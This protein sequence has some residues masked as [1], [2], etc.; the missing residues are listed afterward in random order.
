MTRAAAAL[1]AAALPLVTACGGVAKA[2]AATSGVPRAGTVVGTLRLSARKESAL[3][4]ARP[5]QLYAVVTTG[6]KAQ[7]TV[8]REA[9][10][11][12]T[13]KHVAFDLSNYLA[14]VS[15]GPDGVYA[16]TAVIRRFSD[17]PDQLLRIDLQTLRVAAR[18][19]FGAS[20]STVAQGGSLWAAIGDGRIVR[21]DPRTLKI[22]RSQQ[23]LTTTGGTLLAPAV[24]AGSL[25]VLAGEAPKLELVRLDAATL[26]IRSRTALAAQ[27][28]PAG[29]VHGVVARGTSVYL[30]GSEVAKIRADGSVAWK[31]GAAGGLEAGAVDGSALVGLAEGSPALVQLDA[32][33]RV[34]RRTALRDASAQ[35]AVSGSDAWFVGNG[36]RGEGIVHVRLAR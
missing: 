25:W 6:S 8:V 36:G 11:A 30:V 10:G 28:V 34:V 33:G 17:V 22:L 13:R 16:G 12:V 27:G 19:S 14:N 5:G 21:L 35:L 15:A 9:G 3:L 2:P 32:R 1:A 4:A 23:V 29:S 26:A 7:F 31:S 20:V 24:G 18:A